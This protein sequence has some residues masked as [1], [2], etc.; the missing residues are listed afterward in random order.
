MIT[1][2]LAPRERP[3][4]QDPPIRPVGRGHTAAAICRAIGEPVRVC[5][6]DDGDGRTL[7]IEPLM[8]IPI[9]HSTVDTVEGQQNNV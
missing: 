6:L 5:E 4:R 7:I 3:C 2:P 8:F 9:I 1:N